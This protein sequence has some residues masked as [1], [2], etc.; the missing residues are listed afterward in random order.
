MVVLLLLV[1][2]VMDGLLLTRRRGGPC[3]VIGSVMKSH[4]SEAKSA[5]C[6]LGSGEALRG[7]SS[8]PEHSRG[9]VVRLRL[10]ASTGVCAGVSLLLGSAGGACTRL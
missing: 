1:V 5:S 9:Q 8:T 4:L 2:M 3:W 10:V 7:G 6:R